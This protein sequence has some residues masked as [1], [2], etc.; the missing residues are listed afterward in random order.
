MHRSRL[1]ILT[2]AAAGLLAVACGSDKKSADSTATT[3]ASSSVSDTAGGTTAVTGDTT[4]DSSPTASTSVSPTVVIGGATTVP[5]ATAT[6]APGA[7]QT[8]A[9]GSGVTSPT[10]SSTADSGVATTIGDGSDPTSPYC[11]SLQGYKD[12]ETKVNAVFGNQP[13]A[14][15]AKPLIEAL[16][17]T[18]T[19]FEKSAAPTTVGT[20]VSSIAKP[21][22]DLIAII[23]KLNFDLEAVQ[24][25]PGAIALQSVF[26][27]D[28]T[29]AS[30]YRIHTYNVATCGIDDEF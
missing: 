26:T 17:S 10:A 2:V 14:T 25:D 12:A 1:A 22:H 13:D 21:R 18:M 28:E 19:A 27:S 24:S 20:D 3:S 6:T 11:V 23:E 8:T 7:T 16:D 9:A 15:T 5:G 4:T 29:I 30:S